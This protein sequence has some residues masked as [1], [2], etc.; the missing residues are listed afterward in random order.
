[1]PTARRPGRADLL[2]LLLLLLLARRERR[3]RAQLVGNKPR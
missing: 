2:L 3:P 1:M